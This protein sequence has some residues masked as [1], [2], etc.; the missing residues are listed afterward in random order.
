MASGLVH[1]NYRLPE[2]ELITD[3]NIMAIGN[4][5]G[6]NAGAMKLNYSI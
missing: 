2:W 6:L 5:S 1:G 3:G 4:I